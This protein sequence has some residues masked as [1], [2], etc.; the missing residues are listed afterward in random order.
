M[1]K[2]GVLVPQSKSY[3]SLGKDFINGIRLMSLNDASIIV[4]GIGHGDD[5]KGISERIDKL[6]LQEDVSAIV[7]LFGDH[8]L[9]QI[10]EKVNSLEVPTIIA[11]MGAYPD[12]DVENNKYAFTLSYGLCDSLNFIG[13]W[14]V[15]NGFK[16]IGVSGSF[17]EAGYGFLSSLEKSL[18]EAGGSFTGHYTPP[19]NPRENEAE[20][21]REFYKEVKSDA[22]CQLY[23]GIFAKENIDYLET[24]EGGVD[25]PLVF[26]PFALNGEQLDRISKVASDVYA[27]GTWLPTGLTKEPKNFDNTYFQKYEAYPSTTAMLGYEAAKAL[28]TILP[29]RKELLSGKEIVVESGPL[30]GG[31]DQNLKFTIPFKVWKMQQG[32]GS[33]KMTEHYTSGKEKNYNESFTGQEQ[34]WHN[35][36]LCY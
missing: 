5:S 19:L 14:L 10:Y 32:V 17:N 2:I 8:N 11:R 21:L 28:E 18:T 31:W 3:P 25:V 34:G 13:E 35:A 33:V 27:F 20:F 26:M 22:V 7:G 16:Q 1:K 15:N 36:Y 24:C 6:V 12:I 29:K 30:K 9:P 4:E 23:N